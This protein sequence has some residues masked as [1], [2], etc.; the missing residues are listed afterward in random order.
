[1]AG[2]GIGHVSDRGYGR[3]EEEDGEGGEGVRVTFVYLII[4]VTITIF[5]IVCSHFDF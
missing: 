2:P 3:S 1:M 5:F 4:H